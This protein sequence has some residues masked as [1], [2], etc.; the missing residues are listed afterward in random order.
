MRIFSAEV[1]MLSMGSCPACGC[2]ATRNKLVATTARVS[3]P[4][5]SS[6]TNS[7]IR[8]ERDGSTWRMTNCGEAMGMRKPGQAERTALIATGA[9]QGQARL[10]L[11]P[12]TAQIEVML[13]LKAFHV[14]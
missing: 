12:V 14:I 8:R 3:E 10:Y 4:T 11:T 7:H 9:A 13:W 5:H 1:S 2:R 6:A